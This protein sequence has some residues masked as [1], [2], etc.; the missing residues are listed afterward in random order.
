MPFFIKIGKSYRNL[1]G[2]TSKGYFISKSGKIVTVKWGSVHAIKRKYYWAG[3]KL[4]CEKVRADLKTQIE[5]D[6]LY[7]DRVRIRLKEGYFK[8]RSDKRIHP[9]QKL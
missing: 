3:S 8:L 6:Q 5:A 9:L 2:T 7:N 1:C 4:P